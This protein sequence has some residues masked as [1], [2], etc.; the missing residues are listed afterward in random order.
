MYTDAYV[1]RPAAARWLL[2]PHAEVPTAMTEDLMCDLQ[3]R[4]RVWQARLGPT[5]RH[6]EP[7]PA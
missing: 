4:G 1:L 5:C 3:K 7:T 2:E 6:W